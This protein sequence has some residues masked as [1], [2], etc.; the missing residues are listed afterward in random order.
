ML[1]LNK[2][3]DKYIRDHTSP[4]DDLLKELVRTSHLK[5]MQPRMVSGHVQGKVLEMFSHMIR[6]KSI[7]EIGTFTGYSSLCLAKGLVENGELH[8]IERNDEV[9][10]IASKFIKKSKKALQIHLHVGNAKAIIPTIPRSFDLAFIDGDKR[11]YLSYYHTVFDKV[12]NGGFILADNVLWDGKII[13]PIKHNDLYTKELLEFNQFVQKDNRVE[14]VLL[15]LRDGMM[16][17]RKL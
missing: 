12:K 16:I 8:T 4:E 11:E 1:E 3:L 10:E 15:P 14:N 9:A 17:I 5:A 2:D 13:E 7:L 6:P